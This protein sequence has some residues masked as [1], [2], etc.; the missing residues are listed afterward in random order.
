LARFRTP[1][2]FELEY[3]RNGERYPKSEK[4]LTDSV[5]SRVG[6]KSLVNFGPLTKEIVMCNCTHKIDFFGIPYFGL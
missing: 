4:Y 1:F 5:S 2:H 6:Q 3:L